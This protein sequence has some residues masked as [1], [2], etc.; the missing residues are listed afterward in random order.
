[1]YYY[2]NSNIES[3]IDKIDG[4]KGF[5]KLVQENYWFNALDSIY[6]INAAFPLIL[7]ANKD[8]NECYEKLS[9]E[10][11]IEVYGPPSNYFVIK[12]KENT[13]VNDSIP[14]NFSKI[15]FTD[16]FEGY[17][18]VYRSRLGLKGDNKIDM[19]VVKG[20]F[21]KV[22][23]LTNNQ[24]P[25]LDLSEN[26]ALNFDF[27]YREIFKKRNS[28][29]LLINKRV[30]PYISTR[31]REKEMYMKYGKPHFESNDTIYYKIHDKLIDDN[32]YIYLACYS[33]GDAPDRRTPNRLFYRSPE[34]IHKSHVR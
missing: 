24:P 19:S 16:K 30:S 9:N 29:T 8:C 18:K 20:E 12:P 22:K 2:D 11:I 1:M 4:C 21:R 14:I 28:K 13:I 5:T 32:Y 7:E 6:W 26:N 27:Q 17:D 10:Q 23:R 15:W 34:K 25:K 33:T 31:I 3:E